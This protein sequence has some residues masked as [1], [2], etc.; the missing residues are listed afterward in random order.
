MRWATLFVLLIVIP[1]EAHSSGSFRVENVRAFASPDSSYSELE[2]LIGSSNASI[3]INTYTLTSIDAAKLLED[4]EARGI[5][6]ILLLDASPVGG[7]PKNEET[8]S[9][10]LLKSGARVCFYSS[11][12]TRFNH[13][14]YVIVDNHSTLVSTEN[15]GVDG[16][17]KENSYGERGWGVVISNRELS[18]SFVEMFFSDLANCKQRHPS[19]GEPQSSFERGSYAPR[20]QVKEFKGAYNVVFFAAPEDGIEPILRLMRSANESI[21]VEQAYIYPNW[22]RKK[23]GG[24]DDAPNL[25]LE[26]AI[27]AARRGVKVRILMDS[28]WYNVEEEDATSNLK[29]LEYVNMI[30]RKEGLDLEA[31]L[32]QLKKLGLLRLHAKGVIVDGR[33]VLVS[34][35]N[36]NEHSPTKNREIGVVVYGEPAAY[37]ADVFECDWEPSGCVQEVLPGWAYVLGAASIPVAYFAR[38]RLK[39]S[40]AKA[41]QG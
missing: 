15:L 27:D 20:Y 32:I 14:K 38:K 10:G 4:A 31:R 22:G 37:F 28:F 26:A 36:W 16:F 30:A 6:V 13:A 39:S 25:F 9:Y 40:E 35:I 23:D 1:I 11:N 7:I 33:A 18:E 17:P 34:S 21:L 8:I 41:E 2:R 12:R 5:E 3:Y 24:T 19:K 29:T